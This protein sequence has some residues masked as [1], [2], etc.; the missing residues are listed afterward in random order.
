MR[1]RFKQPKA[2]AQHSR[3]FMLALG[4]GG[5]LVFVVL[6]AI[7][8]NAP[9]S[10]PGRSYYNVEA[11][12]SNADNIANHAQVRINGKLVGQVLNPRAEQ[13]NAV[14][15]LQMNPEDGPLKSDTRIEVRP[16]SA[17]GVRYLDVIPGTKGRELREGER[18]PASQTNAT[19]PLDEVLGVLD[20][21]TRGRTQSF[22]RE[23]GVGAAGRGEDLNETL[24]GGARFLRDARSVLDTVS[25]RDGAMR[26]LVRGAGTIATA[27][28]PV[29]DVIRSGFKPE[30]Q[31]LRPFSGARDALQETLQVAP[32]ALGSIESSLRATDP[33]VDELAGFSARA[34]PLLAAA[35]G[36]LRQTSALLRESHHGLT[37]ADDTLARA[38]KAVDPTLRLLAAVRPA[39]PRLDGL[40]A[41]ATALVQSL[42]AYG[43]DLM[44]FGDY[45]GEMQ[46]FGNAAGGVLRFNVV[47]PQAESF[48]GATKVSAQ[49]KEAYPTPCKRPTGGVR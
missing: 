21:T 20:P 34:R 36:A 44:R 8:F 3:A 2:S 29:R 33:L 38:G 35:P 5:L 6:M 37:L 4:F 11:E 23:L 26:A 43:C 24:G 1:A 42:G 41:A 40:T 45:W 31:A 10:I 25:R 22:L 14:L 46:H 48:Y 9:N 39:L 19:R 32:G 16:R 13:G 17:V 47:A 12:F 30:A 27:A 28:A 18:I 49:P 15:E 7:G